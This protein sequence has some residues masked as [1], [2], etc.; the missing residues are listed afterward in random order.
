M[1]PIWMEYNNVWG[2]TEGFFIGDNDT[3]NAL[4]ALEL[5]CSRYINIYFGSSNSV[6]ALI[7]HAL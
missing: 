4:V 2:Q 1:G 7:C 3:W 6:L 5:G